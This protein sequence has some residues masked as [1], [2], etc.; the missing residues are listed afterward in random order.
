MA[1]W[2]VRH[3]AMRFLGEFDPQ[4]QLYLRGEEVVVRTERGHEVGQV[5]CAA[6]TRALAMLTEP[7]TGRIV[8]RMN[9]RDRQER[10]RLLQL[11]EQELETCERF[12]EQR[13]L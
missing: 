7:T 10:D 4:M 3:G 11:E 12:V 6:D 2:I 8:R 5:L 13:K 9:D 1:T